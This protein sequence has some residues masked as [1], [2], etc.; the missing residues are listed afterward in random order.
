M[1]NLSKILIDLIFLT[2]FLFHQS[3]YNIEVKGN[4]AFSTTDVI[5]WSGISLGSKPFK[6]I[7]DT[8]GFK[9]AKNFAAQGYIKSSFDVRLI[10]IDSLKANL[11]ISIKEGDPAFVNRIIFENANAS[12]S[13]DLIPQFE[14]ME[15]RIF[16]KY[17]LEN[18]IGNILTSYENN[19]YPFIKIIIPSVIFYSDSSAGKN[20]AD[21]RLQI[22]RGTKNNI[23]KIEIAGN[24]KTKDF[25]ITR[26]L[27]IKTGEVYSQK[28]IEELPDRLNRLRFFDPVS[29]PSYY[30]NS[31]NEGVLVVNI[32]EK[33][34]N[35]FDGILGY[36][37]GTNNQ[38]GYL[39]GLVNVNLRNLFGTGRVASIKWQQVDRSSQALE[40]H[41]LEPWFLGYPFNLNGSLV[42]N[43]QDSSYVQRTFEGSVEFLASEDLSASF[44][45]SS[46]VVIPTINDTYIPQ[47][48]NSSSVTTGISLKYDTRDDPYAPMK[49][50]VFN[51]LESY[52]KK[53]I[54][55]PASLITS[56]TQTKINLQ[57]IQVD[58]GL[59][60]SPFLRQV[61]AFG[62]HGRELL[63][64]SFENSDLYRLGGTSTLRG[65]LENQFLGS[66]IAWSNT[67]YRFL[68][69]R[70]SYI[71]TFFDTGYYFNSAVDKKED[72]KLGY[73]LGLSIET[74]L[75]VL[76]VS[77]ALGQGDSFSEGKIHFGI[78]NEF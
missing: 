62:V 51:N 11:S 13:T 55:G 22:D 33:E 2:S 61:I 37:P 74:G 76:G 19:G 47:V 26:E 4:R 31:K 71:F 10:V 60:Y 21:I 34:T 7:E 17:D 3:I 66:R 32:K 18:D 41:Y 64:S 36:I 54:K 43:K 48:F 42:Q 1:L 8:V 70:R 50:I 40:L 53:T 16:N 68:L 46:D 63:G 65:Y 20:Y 6:G 38:P 25:V 23:D 39:T 77:F 69:A 49:G 58:L 73:G 52:S 75:G 44:I 57:R 72:F 28:R 30:I 27:R 14:F 35:N 12:D 45:L 56:D 67:E 59:Y 78:I 5:T 15:G 9:L 24:T 29:T